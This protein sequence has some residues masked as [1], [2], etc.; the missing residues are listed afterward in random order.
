MI[1]MKQTDVVSAVP[2]ICPQSANRLTVTASAANGNTLGTAVISAAQQRKYKGKTA[3]K[4][5]KHRPE[6][7]ASAAAATLAAFHRHIAAAAYPANTVITFFMSPICIFSFIA[8]SPI[9]AVTTA[10]VIL[11]MHVGHI[12]EPV[13]CTPAVR[14]KY[15]T[16]KIP[17]SPNRLTKITIH[18][19]ILD[20]PKNV[21]GVC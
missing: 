16:H 17:H 14:I 12:A 9:H 3:C 20:V 10:C 11:I 7:A 1:K 18:Y 2:F 4:N 8:A 6:K 21:K 13:I 15:F 5:G 19:I